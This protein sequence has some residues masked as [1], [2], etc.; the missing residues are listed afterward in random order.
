MRVMGLE[1]ISAEQINNQ[2]QRIMAWYF[3]FM[4]RNPQV[5]I[6]I[7]KHPRSV[8]PCWLFRVMQL[9]GNHQ[10][11]K[12]EPVFLSQNRHISLRQHKFLPYC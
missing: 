8:G 11:D 1:H 9:K 7:L 3:C 2:N 4:T 5:V 10:E 6:F 12:D